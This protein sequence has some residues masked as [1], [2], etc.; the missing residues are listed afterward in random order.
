MLQRTTVFSFNLFLIIRWEKC[1]GCFL[2]RWKNVILS[3]DKHD[4][5][6]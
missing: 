6:L 1:L 4:M 3:T 5:L 2:F